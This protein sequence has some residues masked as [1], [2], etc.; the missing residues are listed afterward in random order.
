MQKR[1]LGS[2][3]LEV[4]AIGFGCMGLTSSY[5]QPMERADAIA[6]LRQAHEHGITLFDTAE[7]YGPFTNEQVV[8]PKL[9]IV[10]RLIEGGAPR[11]RKLGDPGQRGSGEAQA[12][13][14]VDGNPSAVK[15]EGIR[16]VPADER[17]ASD[18]GA[19]LVDRYVVDPN[20]GSV[21]AERCG[22]L[23]KRLTVR[24]ELIQ[25]HSAKAYRAPI[26]AG[27]MKFP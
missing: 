1:K 27:E 24:D 4:S 12:R 8:E 11:S 25:R 19:G 26:I 14:L 10:S 21:E 9:V 15:V 6:L 2:S 13:D 7:A 16:R 23:W 18:C 17:G 5:G 20:A 22:R 3:G